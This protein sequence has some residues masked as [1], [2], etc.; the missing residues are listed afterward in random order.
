MINKKDRVILSIFCIYLVALA[1]NLVTPLISD[2]FTYQK[3]GLNLSVKFHHY[4]G[5]SGRVVADFISSAIL[6]APDRTLMS[7]I[8]AL[9]VVG[10]IWMAC[11]TYKDH[12]NSINASSL[13]ITFISYMI[14]NPSIGQTTFWIVGAANYL[15]TSMLCLSYMLLFYRMFDGKNDNIIIALIVSI[16]AGCTNES[17]SATIL[18][19]SVLSVIYTW[20]K[21]RNN[22]KRSLSMTLMFCVGSAILILAPGNQARMAAPDFSSWREMSFIGHLKLH[23]FERLPDTS[24]PISYSFVL[25]LVLAAIA[26]IT[27]VKISRIEYAKYIAIPLLMSLGMAFIMFM[28][29]YFPPR[30]LN[31]SLVVTLIPIGYLL[32]IIDYRIRL[33]ALAIF[34]FLFISSI[35]DIYIHLSK[36][37]I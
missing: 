25:V 15:W 29:P 13:L 17:S 5:W 21:E 7:F 4:M 19:F 8:N 2:D 27:K 18:G 12:V 14:F 10:I 23:L 6:Q 32:N 1:C 31:M 33:L 28:S 16:L 24:L 37:L 22:F 9:P 36:G 34:L 35:P 26:L 30:S 3:L 20:L 11:M